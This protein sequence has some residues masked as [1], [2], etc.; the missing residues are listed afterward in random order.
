MK[1]QT[2]RAMFLL[3]IWLLLLGTALLFG[4]SAQAALSDCIDAT[5]RI[6]AADGKGTGC[7]FEI[8]E[9]KVFV[10][11]NAHVVKDQSIAHCEFWRHGHKSKPLPGRV[12][13]RVLN[14]RCDA[15]IISLDRSKFPLLPR[16]VPIAPRG[17]V[18]QP[19]QTVTSVGCAKGAW[20]TGWKGHVLSYTNGDLRFLPV[21]AGGRSGSAIFDADGTMIVGL[22]R[23]R[24]EDDT[25]GIACSLESL[26][27]E[28]S[29]TAV[30][31][32][33][34][35]SSPNCPSC[36]P[37]G[38]FRGIQIGG[39]LQIGRQ[40]PQ[41]QRPPA[42]PSPWT[43]PPAPMAPAVPVPNP[44]LGEL[45][46]KMDVMIEILRSRPPPLPPEAPAIPPVLIPEV[47]EEPDELAEVVDTTARDGLARIA[48][49]VQTAAGELG[50]LKA[51]Q[52]ELG[53]K[54][55][56]VEAA[57][58]NVVERLRARVQDQIAAGAEGR[59]DIIKGIV[60]DILM[61]HLGIFGVVVFA[62][63]GLIYRDIK[64]KRAT[65]DPLMIEKLIGRLSDRV[66]SVRDRV[67]DVRGRIR[68]RRD[69]EPTEAGDES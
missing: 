19:G 41:Q 54:L 34:Q 58:G 51:S 32:P 57:G 48:A 69:S 18:L 21:P 56:R 8:G 42:V 17:T 66:E 10:L 11:T 61:S 33:V 52:Q 46:H 64:D 53:S 30:H 28:L 14:D 65:G 67:D 45:S 43:S 22:L 68:G 40:P 60:K 38:G 36:P 50:T 27:L 20:S 6:T 49:G 47:P 13:A 59:K 62:A 1:A 26:Y 63:L 37:S 4:Q 2:Q 39:G 35:Y 24:N 23:A 7:V 15:A 5:C 9:T 55:E 29:K 31:R 3:I 44:Q 12:I 16:V 25:Q